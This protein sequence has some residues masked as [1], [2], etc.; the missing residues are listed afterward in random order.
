MTERIVLL[1]HESPVKCK[2]HVR[3]NLLEGGTSGKSSR[4]CVFLVK[5]TLMLSQN[6]TI[7]LCIHCKLGWN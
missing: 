7:E 2:A 6:I 5:Q 1:L 4:K 3:S